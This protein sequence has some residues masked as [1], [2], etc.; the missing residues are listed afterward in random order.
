MV[1]SRG[2]FTKTKQGKSSS[3]KRT[4]SEGEY[5]EPP[6]TLG[7]KAAGPCSERREKKKG[8]PSRQKEEVK[9]LEKKDRQA[10]I[11]S[12]VDRDAGRKGPDQNSSPGE[13]VWMV[14]KSK[15]PNQDQGRVTLN[16]S[17]KGG[18]K[19]ELKEGKV[20][21]NGSVLRLLPRKR[22]KTKE[23]GL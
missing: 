3:E 15:V 12:F 2:K 6:A 5:H 9:P 16:Q 11:K 13:K 21:P 4:T 18:G 20:K 8:D 19:R 10:K 17:R 7:G 14:L 1:R 22:K 23:K